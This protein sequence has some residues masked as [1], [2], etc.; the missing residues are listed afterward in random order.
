M[1]IATR[2]VEEIELVA[3]IACPLSGVVQAKSPLRPDT[4]YDHPSRNVETAGAA[5]I[6]ILIKAD[7][8]DSQER[9]NLNRCCKQEVCDGF[10]GFFTDRL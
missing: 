4:G 1:L 3:V 5:I 9:S 7:S 8:R 10:S 6:P 2:T